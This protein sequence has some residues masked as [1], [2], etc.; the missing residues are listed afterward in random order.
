LPG[1]CEDL[2]FLPLA[3]ETDHADQIA[4]LCKDASDLKLAKRASVIEDEALVR[5][6]V[7]L[8]DQVV[9]EFDLV[10]KLIGWRSG[11]IRGRSWCIHGPE[12]GRCGHDRQDFS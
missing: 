3:I 1:R 9:S 8:G 7:L 6:K 11:G 2:K 10:D 12:A 4:C 5:S